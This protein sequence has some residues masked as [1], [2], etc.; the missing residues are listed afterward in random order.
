[1]VTSTAYGTVA[2]KENTDC[3]YSLTSSVTE[4]DFGTVTCGGL[5]TLLIPNASAVHW[6]TSWY[7][8][9]G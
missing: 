2:L 4:I 9:T 7:S 5:R 6:L 1:M 8:A 3:L